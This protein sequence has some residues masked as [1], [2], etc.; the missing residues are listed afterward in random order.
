MRRFVNSQTLNELKFPVAAFFAW[1][2]LLLLIQIFSLRLLPIQTNF[3]G[4]GSVLFQKNPL[5]WGLGNFDGQHYINIAQ[6]G[7]GYGEHAFFPLYPFL[8]KA[9][10]NIMGGNIFSFNAAGVIISTVA[11]LLGL[12]GFY[13]LARLDYSEKISKNALILLLLFPTSFYL[14][15]VYSEGLFFL[16]VIWS[17]YFY[18]TKNYLFAGILGMF[19]SATRLVG[20]SLFLAFFIDWYFKKSI[21]TSNGYPLVSFAIIPSGLVAYMYYLKLKTGNIM[22]FFKEAALYGEQRSTHLIL[23]PQVLY[24]YIFKILPNINYLY[25]PNVF[26]TWLEFVS[27]LLF[28]VLIVAIYFSGNLGYAIFSAIAYI[29]PTL[30]GSFS[31]LPR[32]VLIVF[33]AFFIISKYLTDK[34]F[35]F[36]AFCLVSFILLMISFGLFSTGYWIS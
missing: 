16:L 30:S 27:G 2:V 35:S 19:A 9:F 8:I 6:N 21:K 15:A 25:F 31:S 29:T 32:Y 33:P 13:R 26:F 4:G 12:I 10:G 18:R 28:I 14:S 7:Y 20:V 23:L 11:T 36:F 5:F 24:R 34:K 22:T 17:F 1:R 3:L